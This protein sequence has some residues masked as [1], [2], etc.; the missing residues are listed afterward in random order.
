MEEKIAKVKIKKV[1][2]M[3]ERRKETR[4]YG[5]RIMKKNS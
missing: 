4:K 1:E 2:I 5:W 3:K